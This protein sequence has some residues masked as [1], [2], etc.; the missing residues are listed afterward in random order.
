VQT[1]ENVL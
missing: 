1:S